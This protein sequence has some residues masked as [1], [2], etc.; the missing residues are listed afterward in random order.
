MVD[1]YLHAL[2]LSLLKKSNSSKP[3]SLARSHS[4]YT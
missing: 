4:G 2:N 3:L 1:R